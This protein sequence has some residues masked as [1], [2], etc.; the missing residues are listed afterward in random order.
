MS[1]SFS[2][3][4]GKVT[5][6]IL[7]DPYGAT[8][9]L[10]K[11][12]DWKFKPDVKPVE[13]TGLD[14]IREVLIAQNGG[15]GSFTVALQNSALYDFFDARK[16]EYLSTGAY[17]Y[18]TMYG[19]VTWGNGTQTVITFGNTSLVLEDTQFKNEDVAKFN[20]SF[21]SQTITGM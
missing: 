14:G 7:I 5:S 15:S 2:L 6:I 3:V 17:N 11:V 4:T 8:I 9:N 12:E 10:S 18:S 16:Q 19:Y 13:H 21:Q 1:N 20:V